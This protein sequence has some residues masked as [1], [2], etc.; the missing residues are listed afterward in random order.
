MAIAGMACLASGNWLA[1]NP[2]Q[3]YESTSN[4]HS[5]S[6]AGQGPRQPGRFHKAVKRNQRSPG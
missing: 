5:N 1:A 4:Y 2:E 3:R 6:G